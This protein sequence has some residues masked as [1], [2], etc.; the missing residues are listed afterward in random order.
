VA[1]KCKLVIGPS[2]VTL[3][4][5]LLLWRLT[6]P[7]VNL[8]ATASAATGAYGTYTTNFPLTENPISDGGKWTNGG[9]TGLDWSNIRTTRGKAY[10]TQAG[11]AGTNDSTAIVTGSWGPTQTVQGAYYRSTPYDSGTYEE[12]E[13]MLRTSI[14]AHSITGYEVTF[15]A[16]S[17]SNAYIQAVRWNGPLNSF[18]YIAGCDINHQGPVTGDVLKATM[19]GSTITVYMNNIQIMQCS[20]STYSTGNPGIGFYLQ[21]AGTNSGFGFSAFSATDGSTTPPTPPSNLSTIVH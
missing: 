18:S 21:G 9:V 14:S 15:Q 19:V 11:S 10:G 4:A 2:A 1:L 12:V 13:L 20:D 6:P 17:A 3:V 8:T 5:V 7:G 16:S